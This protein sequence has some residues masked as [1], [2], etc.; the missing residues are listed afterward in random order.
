MN[1]NEESNF[2]D[3]WSPGLTSTITTYPNFLLSLGTPGPMHSSAYYEL[4]SDL[5]SDLEE[6][7]SRR[8]Q[9]G[10][11]NRAKQAGRPLIMLYG[12][13]MPPELRDTANVIRVF[14]N[15]RW[16]TQWMHVQF[17]ALTTTTS[18]PISVFT[19][20]SSFYSHPL[21]PPSLPEF[22]H[23]RQPST[24]ITFEHNNNDKKKSQHADEMHRHRHH[25]H[26]HNHNQHYHF[27][28]HDRDRDP[29]LRAPPPSPTALAQ[30]NVL[31]NPTTTME[32]RFS[33]GGRNNENEPVIDDH[34]KVLDEF[35]S[36]RLQLMF[37]AEA[38]KGFVDSGI[39]I[40]CSF[41][42]V[43]LTKMIITRTF[44]NDDNTHFYKS[45]LSNINKS[46]RR[47]NTINENFTRAYSI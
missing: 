34:K 37:L 32:T 21:P 22:K 41:K 19:T 12:N 30:P 45:V 36:N 27:N 31:T 3:L 18:H 28:Q 43:S 20:P 42:V 14:E 35:K 6:E 7:Q 17:I 38:F 39:R 26:N 1:H 10:E 23:D 2:Q 25:N 11:E 13:N 9:L 4:D 29:A 46:R 24:T 16:I 15:D 33:L 47:L 40:S 5:A 44:T 8:F